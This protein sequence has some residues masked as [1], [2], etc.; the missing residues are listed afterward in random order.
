MYISPCC[1]SPAVGS[2]QLT[3]LHITADRLAEY[4]EEIRNLKTSQNPRNDSALD[5]IAAHPFP[6]P[7]TSLSRNS[8]IASGKFS[9]LTRTSSL[10]N[11]TKPL[12]KTPAKNSPMA[13]ASPP[14]P[15]VSELRIALAAETSRR[16]AAEKKFKDLETELE[17][18]SA[19]LFEQANEMVA[20]ERKEKAKLKILEE[21]DALGQKR[22]EMVEAALVRIERV[23]KLLGE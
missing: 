18:L 13:P 22:L 21:R 5:F 7:P 10:T 15:T 23:K 3:T 9:F 4:E 16:I 8:S 2:L 14:S 11:T 19:T 17:D 20:T 6:A 12:P 1:D